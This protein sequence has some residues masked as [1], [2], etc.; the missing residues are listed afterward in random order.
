MGEEDLGK[1]KLEEDWPFIVS[2]ATK[3]SRVATRASSASIDEQ[4]QEEEFTCPLTK[5]RAKVSKLRHIRVSL[6]FRPNSRE[7]F[8]N[9]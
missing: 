7:I 5:T 4:Q 3:A 1:G 8:L 6:I 9:L 2:S